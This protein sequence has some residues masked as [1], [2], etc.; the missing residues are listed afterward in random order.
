MRP[1]QNYQRIDVSTAEPIKIVILLY[2]GAI[3]NL[4][5]AT[6]VLPTDADEASVKIN[7]TLAIINY[8][9]NALDHEQGGEI[10]ANLERLYDYM[11]DRLAEANIR[12]E[13]DKLGEV[14]GLL[15][16]L[17]EGWRGVASNASTM[18][19]GD[20]GDMAPSASRLSMVVG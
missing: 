14:I 10:S 19:A 8:L 6:R 3:K 2:E 13:S 20:I 15:Q 16:I 4:N 1:Y 18:T 9:R 17:L 7:K 11:R 5:I 12:K